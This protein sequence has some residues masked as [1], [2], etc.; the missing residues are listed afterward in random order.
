MN[1]HFCCSSHVH[2]GS[3]WRDFHIPFSSGVH[4]DICHQDF[5]K[6][7]V[8]SSITAENS[9]YSG[10]KHAIG[11]RSVGS[12]FGGIFLRLCNQPGELW[13]CCEVCIQGGGCLNTNSV[14]SPANYYRQ[15][16]V[17]ESYINRLFKCRSF[18]WFQWQVT[19]MLCVSPS[20]HAGGFIL[21]F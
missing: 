16:F 4:L 1:D 14:W 20:L 8:L 15:L 17:L 21:K 19:D 18:F 3:H 2:R 12:C 5:P 7:I 6:H 10:N 11:V 9:T 13:W